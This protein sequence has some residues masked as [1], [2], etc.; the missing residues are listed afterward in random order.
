MVALAM[1]G[2]VSGQIKESD[3]CHD[4][5]PRTAVYKDVDGATLRVHLFEPID[6]AVTRPRPAIVYFFGGGWVAGDP[7]QFFPQCAYWAS[8]GLVAVSAEYRTRSSHGA[9]PYDAAMDA[10][11]AVRWI[12]GNA[13]ELRI[14]PRRIAVG[15]GSSGGHLAAA[16][17]LLDGFD[18]PADD[19]AVSCRPDALVLLNPVL[20]AGPDQTVHGLVKERWREFSPIHSVVAGAPP[21]VVFHGTRDRMIPPAVVK[22]FA[23]R[24]TEVGARC[25][26][27]LY[28]G[29]GHGFSNPNQGDGLGFGDVLRMTDQFL[30]SLGFVT[31]SPTLD[32]RR[33][34]ARTR[35][36]DG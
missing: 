6:P 2:P 14:D 17:A 22:R 23:A 3:L 15:G 33:D 29:K 1:A 18:D 9:S 31:G 30:R 19:P 13:A 7:S 11:S 8:R 25:E 5:A 20:D 4:R 16:A 34:P 10:R 36:D 21:T 27:Y 35:W 24:M 26:L 28:D 12:R 32:G